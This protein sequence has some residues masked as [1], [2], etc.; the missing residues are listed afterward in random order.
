M[1]N[2]VD[3]TLDE[4]R[5]KKDYPREPKYVSEYIK[6]IE[7]GTI[8]RYDE[9]NAKFDK[10]GA[11]SDEVST[12]NRIINYFGWNIEIIRRINIPEGIRCPDIRNRSSDVLEYWDIKGIYK[13]ITI[14]SRNN[15]ISHAINSARG[16]AKNIIIDINN[17]DCELDNEEVIKQIKNV[18]NN[19]LNRWINKVIILGKNEFVRY[20]KR[21]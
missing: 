7:D 14:N 16:Q 6:E 10:R 19:K 9:S 18:L 4:L 1:K 11:N 17:K 20:Y 15:K 5:N 3:I 13:S 8:I 21:K 12:I 2:Y